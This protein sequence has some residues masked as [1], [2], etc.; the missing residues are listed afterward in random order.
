MNKNIKKLDE[1]LLSCGLRDSMFGTDYVR[2]AVMFYEPGMSMTKELYPAVA[3]AVGS[4]S[5]RVE[6]CIRS[7]IESGFSRCGCNSEVQEIFRNCIAPD[8][9]RPTNCE[10]IARLAHLCSEDINY[11]K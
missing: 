2:W 4:S 9:V 1:M 8:K 7:A 11:E 5:V 10:F 6:R 3:S